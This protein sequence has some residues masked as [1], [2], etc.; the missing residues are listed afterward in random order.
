MATV[1]EKRREYVAEL[2]RKNQE[3]YGT[4]DG[5]GILRSLELIFEHRWIYIF[6]L[7]QNALDAS[8]KSIALEVADDGDTLVFQHDGKRGFDENDVEALSKA[9]RS[10]KSASSV[11]FMGI[12]FKSVFRRFQEARISGWGWTFRY[13]VERVTGA[14]FGDVQTD[15]LGAVVPIWD[16]EISLPETGFTTRFELS[17]LMDQSADLE[18]DLARFLPESDRTTLAILAASG[19]ERLKVNGS[20]WELAVTEEKGGSLEA[21][22]LS[23]SESR[24]WQLFST[25]FEPTKE[26]IA[27]FLEHRRIRPTAE[28]RDRVYAEAGQTPPDSRCPPAG[29]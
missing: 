23:K 21:T 20:V 9:F 15:L 29:Q 24:F 17:G 13:E 27:V 4:T 11:G 1:I 14:E 2:A 19:L 8:A 22:A 10:T 16:A 28:E 25:Q 5:R 18:S 3:F 12:G 26:A 7:I 6:E